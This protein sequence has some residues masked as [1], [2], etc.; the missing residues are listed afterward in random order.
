[1]NRALQG[2]AGRLETLAHEQRARLLPRAVRRSAFELHDGSG[3]VWLARAD[4]ALVVRRPLHL[5]ARA[6][7]HGSLAAVRGRLP[8]QSGARVPRRQQLAA[9]EHARDGARARPRR[10]REEQLAVQAQPGAGRLPHRRAGGR[11]CAPDRHGRRAVRPD[12]RRAGARRRALA[13][14]A[15]RSVPELAAR[16][17]SAVRR[18]PAARHTKAASRSASTIC[19]ARASPPTRRS[20]ARARRFRRRPS[21][22]YCGSS[23]STRPSS[24]S[25]SATCSAPCARSRS[26][27]IPCSRAR[28]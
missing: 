1:M 6:A 26:T 3:R 19:P 7:P 14:G 23:P 13:R 17:L 4:A 9:R 24:R 15:H 2:Y 11:A 8:R 21:A 5:S 25:G 18:R 27:S 16:A 10:L 28:S 20:S 22:T 12:S